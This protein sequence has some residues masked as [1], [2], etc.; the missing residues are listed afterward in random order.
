M[1]SS[2]GVK[3]I[4]VKG[5]CNKSSITATTG[6]AT[7]S[8]IQGTRRRQSLRT[9]ILSPTLMSSQTLDAKIGFS[10]RIEHR[11]LNMKTS[12]CCSSTYADMEYTRQLLSSK[13]AF[14]IDCDG[15]LYHGDTVLP[16]AKEFINYLRDENKKYCFLTNSSD[17]CPEQ[18]AEKFN[19]IGLGAKPEDF[20]TSAMSTATFLRKQKLGA[21]AYVVGEDS[22]RKALEKEGL[23]VV[24]K[25]GAEMSTPDFVVFGETV[26]SDT[27]N[28]EEVT[29]AV[30]LVR[31][32]SRLI[33]TNEDVADRH[34][35]E[36]IPG[37]GALTQPVEA[38]SGYKCYYVGKPNPLMIQ[39]A[40]TRLQVSQEEACM[41]GDRMN[42]DIQ[43]GVEASVDTVLVLSGVATY[44]DVLRYAFR[45]STILTTVGDIPAL[46]T[47][48]GKPVRLPISSCD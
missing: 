41:V 19:R 17:R 32:G 2:K 40:L 11:R 14:I 7:R 16:G 3:E 43:A 15:V 30:K 4:I 1:A 13:N 39:S 31:R 36:L 47:G 20:Y 29:T 5:G 6:S 9:S 45:P 48:K 44:E 23:K 35:N 38:A 24:D 33:G 34:G 26:S 37:T 10:S 46:C 42:T 18:L 12:I 8:L 22:L 28:Y 25:A 21:R 27:F